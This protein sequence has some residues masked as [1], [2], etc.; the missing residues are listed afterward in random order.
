MALEQASQAR[1]HSRWTDAMRLLF[2]RLVIVSSVVTMCYMIYASAWLGS[3]RLNLK[4]ASLGLVLTGV[5]ILHHLGTAL[6]PYLFPV[7]AWLDLGLTMLESLCRMRDSGNLQEEYFPGMA[8][9]A[10]IAIWVLTLSLLALLFLKALYLVSAKK[11]G[12]VRQPVVV[13]DLQKDPR[14]K[15]PAQALFGRSMWEQ[16]VPGEPIILSSLRGL[17]TLAAVCSLVTFG[18]YQALVW[19]RHP[20]STANLTSA[21]TVAARWTQKA[22]EPVQSKPPVAVVWLPPRTY[23]IAVA[24]C[25][26]I[27]TKETT[28]N[29]G[30]GGPDGA[31]ADRVN[32]SL[33]VYLGLMKDLDGVFL[34]TEPVSLFPGTNM[35]STLENSL[36]AQVVQ[37]IPNPFTGPTTDPNIS[38]LGFTLQ[39]V[40]NE[41]LILQDY[42]SKSVVSGFT[43]LGGL[44][45]FLSTILA[46]LLGTSL[47]RAIYRA[48]PYS[49]FG[50]LHNLGGTEGEYGQGVQQGLS[51]TQS[52]IDGFK[53]NPGIVA[54]LFNTLIDFETLGYE[55]KGTN[56]PGTNAAPTPPRGHGLGRGTSETDALIHCTSP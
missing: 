1:A 4:W 18:V 24:I 19:Y 13:A 29:P 30:L 14:W 50:F 51:C 12:P 44:G 40:I 46:M 27:L 22:S 11:M 10:L 3:N 25:P 7:P 31:M 21:V 32:D 34:N 41:W 55:G 47:I 8:V 48:K 28:H 2:L 56:T 37:T 33:R 17:L 38:T 23:D 15:F 35:L 20:R 6:G 36:V 9:V 39:N 16:S 53:A 45:S 54:Y 5:T 42:R 43:A 49:P 26:R 52:D